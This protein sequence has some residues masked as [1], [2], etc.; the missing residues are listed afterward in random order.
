M[1]R[2][3]LTR[4]GTRTRTLTLTL[5]LALN[6]TLALAR[7]RTSMST[8][9]IARESARRIARCSAALQLSEGGSSGVDPCAAAS[10]R[11]SSHSAAQLLVM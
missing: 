6:L 7:T 8:A 1:V 3:A 4:T 9:R 10:S 11:T 5:T 2:L